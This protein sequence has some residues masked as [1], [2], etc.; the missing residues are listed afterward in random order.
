MKCK[1]VFIYLSLIFSLLNA[2][3]DN[4]AEIIV[5]EFKSSGRIESLMDIYQSN[6]WILIQL[7][8]KNDTLFNLINEVI[9][10]MELLSG[11]ASYHRIVPYHL[12]GKIND[13]LSKEYVEIIN[14]NYLIHQS[15]REFW[16]DV[17]QGSETQGTWSDDGAIEYTCS[18]LSGATDCVKLGWDEDWWNPLDY[19]GEAWYGY[20][21][22]TYQSIE[23][24][25]VVVKGGQCD[26]LP[27]WSETYMGMM[28][29]NETWS[30]DYQLSIDYTENEYIVS[31]SWNGS[32]LMPRIGS[33]DNYCIDN[34]RLKFY[35]TCNEPDSVTEFNVLD[36]TDCFT[37]DLYWTLP[38]TS[39]TNQTL[40]R[41][42][43]VIA[44]LDNNVTSY[45]DW[46]AQTGI[47]HIYCLETNN[48]CGNSS[49]ICNSGSLKPYPD[50]PT[51][52]VA[53]D[54][55]YVNQI[56]INWLGSDN[57]DQYKI[58]RDGSWMGFVSADIQNYSDLF[59]EID[60]VYEYCI[61]SINECGPS[62]WSCDTGF[63]QEM[64]GDINSDGSIDVL[65]IIIMVNII[66]GSYFPN[67]DEL[68]ESDVN[69]DGFI[70]I[71]D[72]VI[73]TNEIL[74]N[75]F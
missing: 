35:Y 33:E 36:G 30:Q 70:N 72:V 18:C 15:Y 43:M 10:D 52:V 21:P 28:D 13:I 39:I 61:E 19:W 6:Q 9:P 49:R 42:D 44:Q 75:G 12:L 58:Y 40:Y 20:Q 32:M 5:K 7:D 73:I 47:G 71:L 26:D 41:D 2:Q 60:T 51:N 37:I 55:N 8:L 46:G 65:D 53:S 67:G 31:N 56:T 64:G 27:L 68:I 48:E 16:I 34:I 4:N 63:S 69:Y 3:K 66:I 1:A 45:Q 11:P 74:E 38:N 25:R 29:N 22:P 54:G 62:V 57:T 14:N 17:K 24:I 23:E 59:I 50:P